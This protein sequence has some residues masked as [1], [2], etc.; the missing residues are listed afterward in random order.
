[1]ARKTQNDMSTGS[2]GS[3]ASPPPTPRSEPCDE[4]TADD[5][6]QALVRVDGFEQRYTEALA[7][8]SEAVDAGDDLTALLG[9][10]DFDNGQ[11]LTTSQHAHDAEDGD[12]R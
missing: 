5:Q 7:T 6:S 11:A 4:A 12:L 9:A 3:P 2:R 8:V 10:V 1:M